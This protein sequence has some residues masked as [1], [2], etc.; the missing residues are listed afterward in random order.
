MLLSAALLIGQKKRRRR[1]L[2]L[3]P[4]L[5]SWAVI[6]VAAPIAYSYRYI[7]MLAIG[8]PILCLL[9]FCA[10]PGTESPAIVSTSEQQ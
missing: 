8:L 4:F 6:M 5:A 3:S 1:M 10:E 2:V 7:L 9:P